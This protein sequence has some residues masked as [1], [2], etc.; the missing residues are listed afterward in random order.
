MAVA[1]MVLAAPLV[2]ADGPKFEL[3]SVRPAQQ[4]RMHNS[5]DP[6]MITLSGDPLI[7]VLMEAF[8]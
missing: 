3:A 4:C 6:A 2:G 5:V 1:A 8:G 7:V